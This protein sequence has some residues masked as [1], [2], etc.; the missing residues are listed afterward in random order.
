MYILVH[1]RLRNPLTYYEST[2]YYYKNLINNKFKRS[3][4]ARVEEMDRS[5]QEN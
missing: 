2:I 1:L 5:Y 4:I 3:L